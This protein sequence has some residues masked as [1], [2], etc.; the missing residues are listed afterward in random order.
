MIRTAVVASAL[1]V[2]AGLAALLET[3]EEIQVVVEAASFDTDLPE[4]EEIDVLILAAESA[5]QMELTAG[6]QNENLVP[7]LVLLA[8]E[9]D[10]A[11]YLRA[12]GRQVWGL[13]P[14]ESTIEELLAA[15]RA[16]H[17]GLFIG[18]PELVEPLL[19]SLPVS[20]VIEPL[21][22]DLT[23]RET[24]VLQLLA[25][26]LANKQIALDLGISEHTVKFHV[27]S[28]YTKLNAANRTEAVRLGVRQG[29]IVL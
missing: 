22:D 27:S 7:T 29:L 20:G 23:E 28:I 6:I 9:T 15:V 13:L 26:G 10:P 2:R 24:E 5:D 12:L 17:A 1:A 4:F 25:Q 16:L 3:D 21:V 11:E 18:A 14:L 8:Q 19:A